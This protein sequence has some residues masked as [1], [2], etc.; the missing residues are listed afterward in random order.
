MYKTIYPALLAWLIQ[1]SL[2]SYGQPT[3]GA[4]ELG[5]VLLQND[6]VGDPKIPRLVALFYFLWQGDS[7]SPV[8]PHHWD[9][10]KIAAEHPEVFED[11]DHPAWGGGRGT[12]YFWGEPIYGYYRGDDYWVHLR[13][14][15]LLTDASVDLL[16]IDATNRLTYPEQ[17]E[18]LMKA[19]DAVRAQGK[20]PPAIAYYTNTLSGET[21]RE[22]YDLY[23]REGAPHRHPD[24][25]FYLDGKPLIIGVTKEAEGEK[26]R[27]F[28]TIRE[29]QWPTVPQVVDGW[30][31]ISFTRK[32]QVHYNHRGE[33]EIVNV[34]VAQ[35]PNPAAGMGGSAFYGNRDNWGRSYRNGSHGRPETDMPY[36][37]NIQEQWDYALKEE[38]P[39]IFVTGW[40]EWV[41]GRWD[42]H[43]N[44]PEHSWF[45]DAANAEY[46]R[47]IE[48]SLT[49]GLKDNYYMQL[50]NNI[51]RYKGI[52]KQPPAEAVR[53]MK[54]L[55]DWAAVPYVYTDYTGDTQHRNHPGAQSEPATMYV[56]RTGRNDFHLLKV[57]HDE[58]NMYFYASTVNTITPV[59]EDNRMR[60]Y[61]DTD[62][63]ASTGWKGYDCRVIHGTVLQR[64][65]G[66]VWCDVPG[67][68]PAC[69]V[70]KNEMMIT[71]PR[72]QLEHT[73]NLE[74]KW[75]DNMQ[76]EDP[77]DWYINGDTAP[78]GRFNFI[79][80]TKE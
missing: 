31:W 47:D 10:E 59:L 69:R 70:E 65:D 33:R 26:Y 80:L 48:P 2:M 49:A 12:Y 8:S 51:R 1:G 53:N 18:A 24:C 56:N 61:L 46:S 30:P 54:N 36:G 41:A 39:F 35:H 21:M 9:L 42:S 27:S 40:N 38:T 63:N 72:E 50:V 71:I 20:K 14:I 75:S 68:S 13:N 57:A 16:V 76:A 77:M 23:Y 28:F 52:E 73:S 25:W 44:N 19:M 22:I 60:L 32:P 17:S 45:C 5:R 64:F 6:Q 78:G 15:Q 11:G 3:A 34:S 67:A 37:Y 79:Y 62:R 43:D 7:H 55:R 29:S 66:S 4:D 74:F 58:K